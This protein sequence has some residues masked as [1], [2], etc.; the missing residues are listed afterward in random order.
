MSII[1]L[2]NLLLLML[3]PLIY[4]MFNYTKSFSPNLFALLILFILLFFRNKKV[5]I[6]IN[7]FDIVIFIYILFSL[8][9]IIMYINSEIDFKA[10][11][12]GIAV[13]IVPVLFYFLTR[14][15][16]FKNIENYSNIIVKIIFIKLFISIILFTAQPDFYTD[17]LLF[18]FKELEIFDN[19]KLYYRMQ[20]LLGST[21]IGVICMLSIFLLKSTSFNYLTKLLLAFFLLICSF[22][23]FQRS[24]IF[25]TSIGFI[26]LILIEFKFSFVNVIKF[27]IITICLMATL[28]YYN[29]NFEY[30]LNPYLD[31]LFEVKDALSFND[32]V[33][34]IKSFE[35]IK[36]NPFGTGLGSNTSIAESANYN[37]NGQVVDANHMRILT[38][39]GPIGL[40]LFLFIFVNIVFVTIKKQIFDSYGFIIIGYNLQALGTNVFDSYFSGFLYWMII[41]IIINYN[42]SNNNSSNNNNKH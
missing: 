15:I 31:R 7:T 25:L 4:N 21:S 32:R 12:A 14:L 22:L 41:A 19:W 30:F 26:Y 24:S 17:Y 10:F 9:T 33:S 18:S 3:L 13:G 6:F 2:D 35:L 42:N 29:Q 39:L 36:N 16:Y 11:Y 28:F 40:L 37:P 38:D 20:G 27:L 23:S 34:Y 1:K 8:F 5:K